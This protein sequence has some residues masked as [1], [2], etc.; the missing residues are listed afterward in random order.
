[1]EQTFGQRLKFYRDQRG[2]SSYEL[3]RIINVTQPNIS[4]MEND[5]RVP[6]M[7]KLINLSQALGVSID[8]LVGNPLIRRQTMIINNKEIEVVSQAIQD[9]RDEGVTDDQLIEGIRFIRKMKE[10]A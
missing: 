3:A 1:M 7:N 6:D 10:Q 2:I 8:E 9:A 5:A 4:Q